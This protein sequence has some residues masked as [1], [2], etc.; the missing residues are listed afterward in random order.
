[1]Q[2]M[3]KNNCHLLSSSVREVNV[4]DR[5]RCTGLTSAD[6]TERNHCSS[7]FLRLTS[8]DPQ[9]HPRLC[10]EWPNTCYRQ[11]HRQAC[12][13]VL[14]TV[15]RSRLTSF[16]VRNVN[17]IVRK[18]ST[19]EYTSVNMDASHGSLVVELDSKCTVTESQC[20][21]EKTRGQS[22]NLYA[23]HG[24]RSHGNCSMSWQNSPRSPY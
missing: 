13:I 21:S 8:R 23:Y 7:P 10:S 17:D 14:E 19:S 22:Q 11:G 6:S 3:E 18:A 4:I 1:M 12:G 16:R 20:R 15:W 2:R 9:C 5:L 24:T